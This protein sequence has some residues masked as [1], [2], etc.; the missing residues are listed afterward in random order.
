MP[1]FDVI[2]VEGS[3]DSGEGFVQKLWDTANSRFSE[4][5][6]LAKRDENGVYAGFWGAMSDFSRSFKPWDN[7]FTR[8]LYL[9]GVEVNPDSVP[10]EGWTKWTIPAFEYV[11]TPND[12]PDAFPDG[13]AYLEREGLALAGAV[14][15]Y[16]CPV[17]HKGYFFFPIK[18]L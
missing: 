15:E 11:F 5:E 2:G 7:G 16:N 12:Y 9:A 8:G 18:R 4:V 1:A 17:E 3:T 10:P 13:I 14:Q 6:P